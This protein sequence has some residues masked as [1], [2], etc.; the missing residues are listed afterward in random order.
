MH[1]GYYLLLITY[2]LLPIT[3]YLLLI[4]YYLLLINDRVGYV[5][6]KANNLV[7]SLH[8][9]TIECGGFYH[10]AIVQEMEIGIQHMDAKYRYQDHCKP[11]KRTEYTTQ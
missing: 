11:F 6:D 4:T 10:L 9:R 7:G 1:S 5:G 3:Y 2:Y 8:K